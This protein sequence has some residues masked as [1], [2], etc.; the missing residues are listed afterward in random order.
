MDLT[1]CL[2]IEESITL[3]NM[4]V[5]ICRLGQVLMQPFNFAG[6]AASTKRLDENNGKNRK[7]V[8]RGGKVCPS[9]LFF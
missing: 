2:S 7:R 4:Y 1:S 3:E 5:I 9:I 6:T 8:E